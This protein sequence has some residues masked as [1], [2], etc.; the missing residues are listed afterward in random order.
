MTVQIKSGSIDTTN[1]AARWSDTTSSGNFAQYGV[2]VQM[3]MALISGA[4]TG[5][6]FTQGV[7]EHLG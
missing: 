1:P 2:P 6:P 4:I 7:T 5:G 3:P